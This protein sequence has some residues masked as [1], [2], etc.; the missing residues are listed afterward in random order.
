MRDDEKKLARTARRSAS[1][2]AGLVWALAGGFLSIGLI[3]SNPTLLFIG[4]GWPMWAIIGFT[5]AAL[6][7]YVWFL[8]A[9]A[10]IQQAQTDYNDIM[11][12]KKAEMR[13]QHLEAL[14]KRN[15]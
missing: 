8:Y 7:A 4:Y 2:E 13:E 14:K 11:K 10:V 3:L 6:V 1:N 9:G 12:A 5:V 15:E